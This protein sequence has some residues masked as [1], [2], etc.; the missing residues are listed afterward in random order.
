MDSGSLD[1]QIVGVASLAEPQRRRLYRYVV[2]R[3]RPVSKDEASEALGLA[4]S[5]VTF[6]LDR[7]VADGVLA[8]EYRRLSGRSGPGAGRPAKLYRRANHDVAV[9]L[10]TRTYDLAADLL[11]WA[12][13]TSLSSGVPVDE[14]LAAVAHERGGDLGWDARDRAAQPA[15]LETLVEATFEVLEEQGYEPVPDESDIVL[16]NCPFHALVD[17]HRALVCGLNHALLSGLCEV[18]PEA[19]L[20]ARLEPSP[21]ACCVRLRVAGG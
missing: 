6:H 9:S 2:S 8:V 10:P 3:H 14:A 7:L 4:R 18:L 5:V 19:A 13:T 12:V 11:A 15:D 17:D 16:A 21:V 20:W 1:E